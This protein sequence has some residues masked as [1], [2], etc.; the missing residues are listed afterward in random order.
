MNYAGYTGDGVKVGLLDEYK[1]NAGLSAEL[2]NSNVTQVGTGSVASGSTVH[3]IKMARI[4]CGSNGVAPGCDLY[5]AGHSS[6]STMVYTQME[7]LISAG[8]YVINCSF[9]ATDNSGYSSGRANYYSAREKWIRPYFNKS[10]GNN[11][12]KCRQWRCIH[13]GH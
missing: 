5:T 13:K 8:V 11:C 1:V 3:C 6:D 7:A 2:S 4:I 10:W 9:G 12:K